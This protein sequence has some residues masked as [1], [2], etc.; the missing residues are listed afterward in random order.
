M[1]MWNELSHINN[2]NY[3]CDIDYRRWD[4]L[5]SKLGFSTCQ[6][7]TLSVKLDVYILLTFKTSLLW[8]N[9]P[10]FDRNSLTKKLNLK[11]G[12]MSLL[13]N[14]KIVAGNGNDEGHHYYE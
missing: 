7:D 5:E 10:T 14:Y 11:T 2:T 9:K 1:E 6:S 4:C 13:K 8:F 3:V 12:R